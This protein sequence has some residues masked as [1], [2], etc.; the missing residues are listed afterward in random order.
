M[1]VDSV[2]EKP[3]DVTGSL[4]VN[5]SDEVGDLIVTREAC[6]RVDV[7]RVLGPDACDGRTAG[8]GV[9]LVPRVEVALDQLDCI[10]CRCSFRLR[11]TRRACPPP[12]RPSMTSEVMSCASWA[13]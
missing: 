1:G 11:W 4:L 9:R 10:S 6:Q 7:L 3:E 2:V 8:V 13:G 5:P 12:R